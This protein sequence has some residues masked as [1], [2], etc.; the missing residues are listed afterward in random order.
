MEI[1]G[2]RGDFMA[3][4]FISHHTNSAGSVAATLCAELE[5]Q[6]VSCWY[7]QRDVRTS[8]YAG[9][10]TK[11]IDQCKVFLLLFT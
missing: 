1:R 9:E 6:G 3:D 10:I 4:V 7:A 8:V 5:K 11:A 2:E